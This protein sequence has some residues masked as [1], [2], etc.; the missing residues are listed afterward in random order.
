MSFSMETK[1]KN[2]VIKLRKKFTVT[3]EMKCYD[4]TQ[5]WSLSGSAIKAAI[6]ENIPAAKVGVKCIGCF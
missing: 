1:P 4:H 3:L 2:K 5:R 6:E